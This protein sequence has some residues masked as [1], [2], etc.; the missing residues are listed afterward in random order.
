MVRDIRLGLSAERR[1]A[2][3]TRL[4][5]PTGAVFLNDTLQFLESWGGTFMPLLS[6]REEGGGY[7]PECMLWNPFLPPQH[8]TQPDYHGS[9]EG[10]QGAQ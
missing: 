5:N 3:L 4:A 9:Q 6:L 7:R 8:G 2:W 1:L 10:Q